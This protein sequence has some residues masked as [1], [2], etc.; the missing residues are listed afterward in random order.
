M[1]H[2]FLARGGMQYLGIVIF[3]SIYFYKSSTMNL[4]FLYCLHIFIYTMNV[5]F[6]YFDLPPS[7]PFFFIYLSIYLIYLISLT[8]DLTDLEMEQSIYLMECNS[9]TRT[10]ECETQLNTTQWTVVRVTL[11]F[12][13]FVED[14][15]ELEAES[16]WRFLY[17]SYS[18]LARNRINRYGFGCGKFFIQN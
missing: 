1:C 7:S 9:V 13:L 14:A 2:S 15:Q 8:I 11:A 10:S 3:L 5:L 18:C 12:S 4:L 17:N 16:S 6:L